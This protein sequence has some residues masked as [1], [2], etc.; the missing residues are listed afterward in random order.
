MN[1]YIKGSR[2]TLLRLLIDGQMYSINDMMSE[3][4][5]K[6]FINESITPSYHSGIT[7]RGVPASGGG[8]SIWEYKQRLGRHLRYFL[9]R[10]LVRVAGRDRYGKYW[11]ITEKGTLVATAEILGRAE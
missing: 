5:N 9:K 6:V 3:G 11:E 8:T 2:R 10:G 7:R 1:G 4:P